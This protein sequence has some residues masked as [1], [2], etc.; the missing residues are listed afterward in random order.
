MAQLQ[1]EIAAMV[2]M[3]HKKTLKSVL[4]FSKIFY[5]TEFEYRTSTVSES[6]FRCHV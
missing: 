3:L 2:F 4:L 6:Y 5:C 1:S